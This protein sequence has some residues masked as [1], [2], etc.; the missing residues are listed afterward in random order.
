MRCAIAVI[1]LA[2]FAPIS[3][4]A[5]FAGPFPIPRIGA[6]SV[7]DHYSGY[8]QLRATER[9]MALDVNAIAW[10][11]H[12]TLWLA[13]E[14]GLLRC[15]GDRHTLYQHS[16]KD[17]TSLPNNS[18]T[19]VR[20]ARDGG[21]WV[22]TQAGMA[23]L[24]PVTGRF[25]RFILSADSVNSV[26]ANR[27]WQVAP[28]PD[29]STLAMN[30]L[31]LFRLLVSG[32]FEQLHHRSGD[33]NQFSFDQL[34]QT[35]LLADSAQGAVWLASKTGIFR[36]DP[37]WRVAEIR[38][39]APFDELPI[40]R[41]LGLGWAGTDALI[42]FDDETKS[43]IEADL[44]SSAWRR[45][46][47]RELVPYPEM[48]RALFRGPTGELWV[49]TWSDHLRVMAPTDQGLAVVFPDR[50]TAMA[51]PGGFSIRSIGA[52]AEGRLWLATSHGALA[53]LPSDPRVQRMPVPGLEDG[54]YILTAQP[55][56]DGSLVV[57]TYHGGLRRRD[58]RTGHWSTL[59][60]ARPKRERFVMQENTIASILPIGEDHYLIGTYHGIHEARPKAGRLIH[61]D[62]LEALDTRLTRETFSA[63]ARG[64]DGSIWAA[65]WMKGLIRFNLEQQQVRSYVHSPEDRNS[66]PLDRLLC[67]MMSRSG[68]LWIGANDGGGLSRYRSAADDFERFSLATDD[69]MGQALGVVRALAEDGDGSIWIGTHKGGVARLNP[70]TGR[71]EVFDQGQGVPGDLIRA[72]MS[73]TALGTWIGGKGGL[74][75]WNPEQRVFQRVD[76]GVEWSD[77]V[78]GIIALPEERAMLVLNGS[79]IVRIDFGMPPP[80]QPETA[81]RLLALRVNGEAHN[82]L[83]GF[84]ITRGRDR[85]VI[86]FALSDPI[87]AQDMRVAW[88][89]LGQSEEWTDCLGC[90]SVS[91][92][93]LA[94][95]DYRFEVRALRADGAWAPPLTLLSFSVHPPWW[96]AW[97][98]RLGA[99][100]IVIALAYTV[101]KTYMKRQLRKQRERY[102]REQAVMQER[103]RIASDIH[104]DLGAGL[105]A[106]KLR[107][108][109]ALRVGKD[110]AKREQLSSLAATA[111]DLIGSMR[112][113]IWAMDQEQT[114]IDDLL[115]YATS[116]ARNYCAQNGIALHLEIAKGFP[117]AALRTEQRRNI[118]LVV[119][120][121]LH[122]T[123]KHAQATELRIS[124]RWE[125]GLHLT[126]A[127][128]GIGLP[129][130]AD[131][132]TGNGMRNMRRRMRELGG[133]LGFAAGSGTTINL[134]VP[135][136]ITP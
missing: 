116:Y 37:E 78:A 76:F 84:E 43:I 34:S 68:D 114:S 93:E 7:T 111:G 39:L 106:L 63:L 136:S 95:G 81:P 97:W 103:I 27:F 23:L 45:T 79:E 87:R 36:I 83:D 66:L 121:A 80:A 88:R 122:N 10:D 5:Q 56:P 52:D 124:A 61:R 113:M 32:V 119:K 33:E 13:L 135:L 28:M 9:G 74:A 24:D 107:S 3:L 96:A 58:G 2:L 65:T 46:D 59:F 41:A 73:D 128:N 6:T 69:H 118:F 15:D 115:V 50:R 70:A 110:H 71:T 85:I 100:V 117:N 57:G 94:N 62:D 102:E 131:L 104:D 89:L 25:R 20:V 16:R 82:L 53:L 120:E 91:F 130:G 22:G 75:R 14:N 31:G 72:V 64:P 42:W 127:D 49:S 1:A 133:T 4:S 38:E 77:E 126:I 47:A 18:V 21:I 30:E 29:G 44:K 17:S 109:M 99:L 108:E 92:A 54:Q 55:E 98:F 35:R 19:D 48:L 105:S 12:R 129:T 60:N 51:A 26:R 134:F 125:E 40:G 90:R 112:Q 11:A 86:E 101:F 8:V 132:G 123:V 67:L